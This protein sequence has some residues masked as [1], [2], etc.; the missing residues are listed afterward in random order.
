MLYSKLK[1]QWK[2]LQLPPHHPVHPQAQQQV[3]VLEVTV[4]LV[5]AVVQK[6]PQVQ[7]RPADPAAEV[8]VT[9]DLIRNLY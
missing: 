2:K 4:T 7:V 3:L 1:R 6:V 5:S 9:S 8:T